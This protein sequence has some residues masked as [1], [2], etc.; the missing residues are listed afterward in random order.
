MIRSLRAALLMTVALIVVIPAA[1][2]AK[3]PRCEARTGKTLSTSPAFR[4]FSTSEKVKGDADAVTIRVYSCRLGSRSVKL[5]EKLNNTIDGGLTPKKALLNGEKYT[6]IIYAEET[7]VSAATDIFEYD[8]KTGKQVSAIARDGYDPI[9]VVM[10]SAGGIAVIDFDKEIVA[11]D[12][13][14]AKAYGTGAS[15]LAVGASTIYWTA[16]GRAS[17]IYLQGHP[18]GDLRD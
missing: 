5:L 11:Y 17:S 8:L 14:G 9:E 6:T 15:A 12:K 10:T 13:N 7:G 4:V 3:A 18:S 16:E 1:A 2:Q